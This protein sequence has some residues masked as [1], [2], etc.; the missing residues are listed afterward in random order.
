MTRKQEIKEFIES[1]GVVAVLVVL[2]EIFEDKVED[3]NR[4]RT[5][6]STYWEPFWKA[7]VKFTGDMV[8]IYHEK[9]KGL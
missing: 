4:Y 3:T 6:I 8:N 2:K 1:R 7:G 5:A 9:S